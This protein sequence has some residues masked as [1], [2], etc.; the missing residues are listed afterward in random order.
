[1]SMTGLEAFDSTVQKTNVWLDEIMKEMG[2][3]S[4]RQAY[5]ALRAVLHTLRDRLLADEAVELGA[6]MPVLVRG[7]YYE[8]WK[9]SRTPVKIKHKDEFYD[10]IRDYFT[11]E[12]DLEPRRIADAVLNV[13]QK[14]V[15]EGEIKDV[16]QLLPRELQEIW[17]EKTPA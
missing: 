3:D 12:P 10:C 2:S 1:M 13:L 9:P 4:R 16:K 7:L 8:G 11:N 6:Q 14:H 15:S 5:L 17:P